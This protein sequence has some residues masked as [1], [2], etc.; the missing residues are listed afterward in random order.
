LFFYLSQQL[1]IYTVNKLELTVFF[2]YCRIAKDG[3]KVGF[4][5]LKAV[6]N[7]LLGILFVFV[8][9]YV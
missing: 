3:A 1:F 4:W 7:L 8:A 5:P 9:P 2:F 6:V